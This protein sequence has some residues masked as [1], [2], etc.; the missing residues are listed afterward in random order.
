M[1]TD[2]ARMQWTYQQAPVS[3]PYISNLKES[4]FLSHCEGLVGQH[5][6]FCESK[7]LVK[8][9]ILQ[10]KKSKTDTIEL[11]KLVRIA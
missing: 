3:P 2:T 6:T 10:I 1:S 7:Y 5:E 11:E 4:I 9:L 8:R